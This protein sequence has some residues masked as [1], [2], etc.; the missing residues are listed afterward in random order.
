MCKIVTNLAV[1]A[2]LQVSPLTGLSECT[3]S[4]LPGSLE[5]AKMWAESTHYKSWYY[6]KENLD[7]IRLSVNQ[8]CKALNER[9]VPP[10]ENPPK[11]RQEQRYQRRALI[12]SGA[13]GSVYQAVD[14]KDNDRVVA[15]KTVKRCDRYQVD[16]IHTS[17]LREIKTLKE[18][19]HPN[20]ISLV[21]IVEDRK[22]LCLVLDYAETD[23]AQIIADPS[24]CFRLSNIKAI[25]LM[26]LKGLDYLHQRHILHRDLKPANILV[27]AAGVVKIADFG[28]SKKFGRPHQNMTPFVVTSWYRAPELL[29]ADTNYGVGIDMW[30]VGCI[31]AELV[32]RFPF[33]H[34][35][36]D[37]DM[38][39]LLA[40]YEKMGSP[41]EASWPGMTSLKGYFKM[42]RHYEATPLSLLLPTMTPSM[43]HL[44]QL[45][46]QY[47][48]NQRI[49]CKYAL[50]MEFFTLPPSAKI[51]SFLPPS[52]TA[53][54][55]DNFSS[56]DDSLWDERQCRTRK[57][58][59]RK[60]TDTTEKSKKLKTMDVA[61]E[62]L[63]LSKYE[64]FLCDVAHAFTPSIPFS[65]VWTALNYM[66][67][68]YLRKSVM[69]YHPKDMALACLFLATR[70]DE[71]YLSMER[72]LLALTSKN[73]V[74]T[75]TELHQNQL[76]VMRNIHYHLELHTPFQGV[77]EFLKNIHHCY[78]DYKSENLRVGIMDFLQKFIHTDGVF[79]HTPLRIAL[80]A[81]I[82]AARNTNDQV[83][84]KYLEENI[85]TDMDPSAQWNLKQTL[86]K[87]MDLIRH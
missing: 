3:R 49:D 45:L 75:R 69:E 73:V 47:D 55:S 17:M 72:F 37:S 2:K 27:N 77:E 79:V 81:I 24:I 38:D 50:G 41:T 86:E 46:L 21:D 60:S 1:N 13:F 18:L 10:A 62:K 29:M 80:A 83:V 32:Q 23:L 42:K 36:H 7:S 84:E 54:T 40:I 64:H 14:T 5:N 15:I 39:Q 30:A 66:K 20:I 58:V 16:G 76:I 35:V 85:S 68:F 71:Y 57:G 82:Y 34:S 6:Y 51:A 4:I 70:A 9:T 48:P 44:L 31:F 87:I 61:E 65:V 11:T 12:G 8:R 22:N 28:L 33:F 59:K 25:V 67:R 78:R 56:E 74:I 53:P 52:C 63:L 19:R 43:L 26:I